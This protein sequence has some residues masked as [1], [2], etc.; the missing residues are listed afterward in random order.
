MTHLDRS[1]DTDT[2]AAAHRASDAAA[3]ARRDFLTWVGASSL[4]ALAAPGCALGPSGPRRAADAMNV[5]QLEL[6]ARAKLDHDAWLYLAGGAD[7]ERTVARNVEAFR[8][9]GIRARRLVDVSSVDTSVEL[10][11]VTHRTPILLCPVGFQQLFHREAEV[12]SARAAAARRHGMILSSVS[13]RSVGE[14]ARTGV[15]PL[16]FQLYPTTDRRITQGLLQRAEDAGC[17]VVVLTVDAPV[18]GNRERQHTKLADMLAMG[19][20]PLGNYEGFGEI[21]N[22]FDPTMTWDMVDWLHDHCDM[23]VVLKGVVTAEDAELAVAR[24][25]DGLVVSNHG[26]RQEE[27][28]RAT[29]ECLPEVVAAVDGAMPVL[30]DSGV[31]RGT[32]IFK[33]LALGADAVCVGRPYIWG[34][35]GF[36]QPGVE[37]ALDLLDAELVRIMRLAGVTRIAD[38]DAGFVTG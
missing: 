27:S 2:T 28:D 37:H 14:V 20:L 23:R 8:E 11:G 34:L 17:E 12:V 31:R 13:N 1:S 4:L 15:S 6:A 38:I 22:E 35:A 7:D 21:E 30:L 36:G 18:L 29:I 10:F 16:W 26:G 3:L 24:G 19:D 33:A 5:G 9:I 25:A 32:D